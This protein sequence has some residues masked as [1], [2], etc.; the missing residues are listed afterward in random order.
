MIYKLSTNF[1]IFSKP[2][3]FFFNMNIGKCKCFLTWRQFTDFSYFSIT[4]YFFMNLIVVEKS[5]WCLTR[6]FTPAN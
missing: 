5:S 2:N 3:Y 4:F 1:N 6:G